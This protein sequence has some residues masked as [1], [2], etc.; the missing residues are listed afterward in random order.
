MTGVQ[1][2]ALPIS[3]EELSKAPSYDADKEFDWGDRSREVTI[4]GYYKVP[5][6][7]GAY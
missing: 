5:P 4:H 7:W 2:C 3:D 1:T 6:Y